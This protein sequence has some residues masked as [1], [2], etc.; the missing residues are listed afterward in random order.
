[1]NVPLS[2]A[3]AQ[4]GRSTTC[5]HYNGHVNIEGKVGSKRDIAETSVFMP[6]AC[7]EDMLTFTDLRFKADDQSNREGNIGLGLRQLK[8]TGVR[9]GYV[10]FD[11]KR[12]GTTD[13]YHNQVTLGAEW[14]TEEW[15]VRGNAYIPISGEKTIGTQSSISNPFLSGNSILVRETPG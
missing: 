11:R 7:A 5:A 4:E 9:G 1:M 13:K 12:S 10:Y 14:L 3:W 2:V 15:E 8:E 6:L